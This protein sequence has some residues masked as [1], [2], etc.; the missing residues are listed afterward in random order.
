[1]ANH[2]PK[3]FVGSDVEVDALALVI[4]H[5]HPASQQ[6]VLVGT[7]TLDILYPDISSDP[8]FSSFE[9]FPMGYIGNLKAFSKSLKCVRTTSAV[10]IFL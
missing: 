5:L 8:N 2:F 3:A 9:P 7:K 6:Q 1:M 4:P 10:E